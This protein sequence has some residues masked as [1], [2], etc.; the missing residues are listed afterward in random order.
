MEL[1]DEW[2]YFDFERVKEHISDYFS[3][4]EKLEYLVNIKAEYTQKTPNLPQLVKGQREF[5]ELCEAEISRIKEL[6]YIA[7]LHGIPRTWRS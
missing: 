1:W 7:E 5:D 6:I 4:E 2:D 3:Y